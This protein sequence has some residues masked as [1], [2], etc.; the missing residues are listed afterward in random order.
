MG[1]STRTVQASMEDGGSV[2][3]TGQDNVENT[4]WDIIHNKRFYLAEQAPICQGKIRG[5]F[6]YLANTPATSQF[7]SGMYN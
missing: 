3:F 7:L 1:R 5:D 2:D 6:G 4:I